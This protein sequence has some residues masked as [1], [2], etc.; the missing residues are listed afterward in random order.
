MLCMWLYSKGGILCV[1]CQGI[2]HA[3]LKFFSGFGLTRYITC[4]IAPCL[5]GQAPGPE[6]HFRAYT[7]QAAPLPQ[8]GLTDSD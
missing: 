5:G 6:A 3:I 1:I 8:A 2:S 4:Y 7:D